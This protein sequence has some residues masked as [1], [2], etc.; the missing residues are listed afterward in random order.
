MKLNYEAYKDKVRACW[1]GKN[2]GGTLGGP[3]EG[4]R[5]KLDVKGFVTEK[6]EPLPND[7][8]DLQ[9][10][11]L[12]AIEKEGP[13]HLTADVLGDYWLSFITMYAG[14]YS[15]ARKNMELGIM[16]PLSGETDNN[17]YLKHSNGA[18]IRTEVW[19]TLFPAQPDMAVRYAIEDAKVDH[20]NGEGTY[21]AMFVA[22]LESAAFVVSDLRKLIEI[23]LAKI[24]YDCRMA[25]TVRLIL[26]CYDKGVP[27][28]DA[29]DAILQENADI[30][31]GWFSAPSNVG[32]ATL[33]LLYGEGDFK[34]SMLLAVNCGDDT[35]CTAGTVGSVLGI[36]YGT[37]GIPKDWEEYIGD[38]IVTCSINQG[39]AFPFVGS[40][41][42]LT[43]KV[44]KLAP[45][46][47]Y[48]MKG[49][50]AKVPDFVCGEDT[51]VTESDIEY[52]ALPYGQS[53]E[54]EEMAVSVMTV[55]TPNTIVKNCGA[56]YALVTVHGGPYATAGAE[57]RLSIMFQ[58]RLKA[59]GQ[60]PHNMKVSLILPEGWS[61]NAEEFDVFVGQW[62]NL[63]E[64][65]YN[66]LP[67]EI[68]LTPPEKIA[69]QSRILVL[70][71]EY[72]RH[73]VEAIPVKL[74]NR[75]SEKPYLY[76]D[77]FCDYERK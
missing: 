62:W 38:K 48:Q 31:D 21:A 44:V 71:E 34:K 11:W 74:V 41:T 51:Q 43:E 27:A 50:F 72:G 77:K 2:I 14:E 35:D 56:V 13:K 54:S 17:W 22:A 61:A 64:N 49:A 7:D 20:G 29:R 1:I 36:M 28:M 15:I 40:C 59:F 24:P 70:I 39:T 55:R 73:H 63:T 66:T 46:F 8:L 33:G 53:E 30:G 25:R 10:V 6:G 12:H 16:P 32:Y 45:M 65:T 75:L 5:K 67:V 3:F 37:A 68:V 42:A 57:K 60:Q 69:A 18:W 58:N 19:A 26:D 52:F 9:L 4:V 76:E 23:G 47:T